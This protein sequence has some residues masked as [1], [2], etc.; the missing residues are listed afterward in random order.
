VQGYFALNDTLVELPTGLDYHRRMIEI[1][2]K[3]QQQAGERTR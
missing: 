2:E 3:I 1:L